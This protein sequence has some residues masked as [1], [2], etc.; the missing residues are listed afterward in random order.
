MA[1]MKEQQFTE[2]K[3]LLPEQRGVDSDMQDKGEEASGG[4]PCPASPAP[5]TQPPPQSRPTHRWHVIARHWLRQARRR[6]SG[7]LPCL[8]FY[9]LLTELQGWTP[10]GQTDGQCVGTSSIWKG[11]GER[12]PDS[13]LNQTENQM[14]RSKAQRSEPRG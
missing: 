2:E 5:L 13:F 3:P 12:S 4:A 8:C 9:G 10:A 14:S 7:V 1:G 11:G 6:T